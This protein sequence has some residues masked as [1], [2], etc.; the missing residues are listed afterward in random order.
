MIVGIIG[1][2]Q[3]ARMLALAGQPLGLEF[4]FIDPGAGIS[5][6]STGQHWQGPYDDPEL[7]RRLAA[8]A[9][10]AT[11]EFENVPPATIEYLARHMAVFPSVRALSCARDR[12]QEKS[13]F[14]RLGIPTVPHR[15]VNSR[16]ELAE[17]VEALG[18]P[19]VL[20]TR[21]L[22]YDGKGQI[23]L[24]APAD[25]GTAWERL[26]GADLI[27]EAFVEFQREVSIIAARNRAGEVRFYPLSENTHERGV[28]AFSRARPG[29]PAAAEACRYMGL[30]LDEFAYVGVLAL[31]LFDVGG[32]LLANEM[33]PRV[34]NSGHWT[35]EGSE[36]S[37][38]ENHLRAVL[39]W[40]L[41]DT[42]PVGYTAMFNCVG[43]L[44]DP[45][46][47][48][49]IGGAHWHD[50]RKAVRPGRKVGHITAR[51]SDK[52][53]LEPAISALKAVLPGHVFD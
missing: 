36:T 24:R 38:F 8:T 40:P 41:G 23:V 26:G 5:A 7:L 13:L 30:L 28:L 33:A 48:M 42:A 27:L 29:D 20:K 6:A 34:H 10:V 45:K 14:D 32:R 35:I 3:L 11:Y 21:R 50:Y 43:Y 19:A 2:G 31:E 39:G 49:A 47:V 46:A 15:P 16:A 4:I 1:G 53:S 17:A 52:D 12:L 37:Q 22:G 18:L 44:P 25:I 9:D 51:A